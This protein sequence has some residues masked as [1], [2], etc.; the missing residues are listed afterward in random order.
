MRIMGNN[1]GRQDMFDLDYEPK[2]KVVGFFRDL[3]IFSLC[4][5]WIGYNLLFNL[6]KNKEKEV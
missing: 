6:S 5:G 1:G 2:N 3:L 4:W